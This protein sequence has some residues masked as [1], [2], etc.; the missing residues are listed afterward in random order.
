[1][2]SRVCD[3]C[4][5]H[6]SHTIFP[7]CH[8]LVSKMSMCVFVVWRRMLIFW[9][10]LYSYI[11]TPDTGEHIIS[12][13]TETHVINLW[14]W[15]VFESLSRSLRAG[16]NPDC[17]TTA[18]WPVWSLSWWDTMDLG[19]CVLTWILTSGVSGMSISTHTVSY[20]HL[21]WCEGLSSALSLYRLTLMLANLTVTV[22]KC[23][24]NRCLCWPVG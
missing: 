14:P 11:Q 24:I 22:K 17:G 7:V 6:V 9:H 10:S 16:A 4:I 23:K 3:V 18:G 21:K 8:F 2:D 1:M 15:G 12:N 13:K 20:V 19:W 5:V